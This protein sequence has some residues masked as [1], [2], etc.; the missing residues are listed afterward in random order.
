MEKNKNL[1]KK[2]LL[3]AKKLFQKQGIKATTIKQIADS[4]KCTNA[5]LYY[6]F[7]NGKSEIIQETIF[8]ILKDRLAILEGLE[9][10][11]NLN[12][13]ITKLGE[14]LNTKKYHISNNISWL[15][16]EFNQIPNDIKKVFHNNFNNFLKKLSFIINSFIND[17]ERSKDIAW[18]LFCSIFGYQHLFQK[19][20]FSKYFKMDFSEFTQKLAKMLS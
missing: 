10:L 9:N 16:V 18:I 7:E 13:F 2:L 11:K 6:Y 12:D 20:D 17:E 3:E 5:A 4:S 1:K 15:L 19:M 14:K 8:D